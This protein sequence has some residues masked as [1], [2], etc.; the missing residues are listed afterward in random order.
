M[1]KSELR[2]IIKEEIK[3]LLNEGTRS[4]IG[5]ANPDGSVTSVYAQWE[6]DLSGVGKNL[7]ILNKNPALVK[8]LDSLGD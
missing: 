8:K 4:R 6:G 1:K 7:K 5:M 3:S 2:K